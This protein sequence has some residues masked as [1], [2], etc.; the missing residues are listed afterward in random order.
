[1][2]D[3][4][5]A[6]VRN[7]QRL[8]PSRREPERRAEQMMEH[9]LQ[10]DELYRPSRFWVEF[11][12][13]NMA[14]LRDRGMSH[15]KR[16]V[17]QNYFNWMVD[18]PADPQM[19]GLLAAWAKQPDLL[20]LQAELRGTSL[21]TGISGLRFLKTPVAVRSYV[22]FV[23]LLWWY[24]RLGDH[25]GCSDRL[26]EP[27]VGDPIPIFTEDRR[28]SQ[29]LANSLR[30]YQRLR[31]S[32]E[33][34][35]ADPRPILAEIGAG[36]GRLGYVA[37][38]AQPLRYWI[39][40]IP[41][42]LTIAEWYLP[43]TMKDAKVFRWRPFSHWDEV[44]EEAL[45]ADLAFFT[46]DQLPLVPDRTIR[47]FAAISALHEMRH[48]Q[49]ASYVRDIARTTTRAFYSKNWTQQHN[50]FDDI[51]FTTDLIR[52]PADWQLA[53]QRVDDVHPLFSEVLYQ[54]V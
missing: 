22:L 11:S 12:R 37:M 46:I 51:H 47:S 39:F 23:G 16:S 8:L 54:R 43:R 25:S 35:P 30:E 33:P 28:I 32:L 50:A 5:S 7:T 24:A 3:R 1:V 14:M 38:R 15:F 49:I 26:E 2:F 20:P 48:D 17:P 53:F 13:Q 44:A 34:T 41:P 9:L 29:D 6:G 36:Y 19:A 40:D 45:S 42:A 52:M 27:A 31:P 4:I 21:A 18:A 10:V